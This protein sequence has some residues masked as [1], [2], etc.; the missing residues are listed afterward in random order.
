MKFMLLTLLTFFVMAESVVR[1]RSKILVVSGSGFWMG[2]EAQ[3]FFPMFDGIYQWDEEEAYY[4]RTIVGD[5]T[6][7]LFQSPPT[8]LYPVSGAR[9]VIGRKSG[10][11]LVADLR[12][13][14]NGEGVPLQ[15]KSL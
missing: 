11:K 1:S 5:A 10:G 9:W 4:L 6:D 15:G 13:Q 12:S 3:M 2:G 14:G 8:Y 7:S